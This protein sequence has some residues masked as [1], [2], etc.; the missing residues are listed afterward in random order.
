MPRLKS[1]DPDAVL[2]RAIALF[3]QDGYHGVSM[4]NLVDALQLNRASIY[5]TFGD[6]RGLYL[7]SLERYRNVWSLPASVGGAD[8]LMEFTRR[9]LY[10]KPEQRGCYLLKAA[11]ELGQSDEEVAGI[12]REYYNALEKAFRLSL[13]NSSRGNRKKSALPSRDAARYL[14]AQCHALHT[15]ALLYPDRKRSKELMAAALETV[16]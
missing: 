1:F 9:R 2:D 12:T 4:S 5:N 6:K 14:L 11:S 15:Q 8:E 13:E 7:S 3:Y 10:F 16:R